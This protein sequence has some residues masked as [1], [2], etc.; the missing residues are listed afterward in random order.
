MGGGTAAAA[1]ARPVH[2]EEIAKALEPLFTTAKLNGLW[3]FTRY[4]QLWF[5]PEELYR[6]NKSGR[7]LWGPSNWELRDPK[8]RLEQ[9]RSDAKTA[10]TA[11]DD[12]ARRLRA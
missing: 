10:T 9:L 11:A 1:F 8:E 3:F 4:Q 7:F 12:F 5:S 2:C 6:E